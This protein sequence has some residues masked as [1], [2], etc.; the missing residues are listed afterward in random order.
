MFAI[1][2]KVYEEAGETGK[3][4]VYKAKFDKL[5][6]KAEADF[7]KSNQTKADAEAYMQKHVDALAAMAEQDANLVVNFARRC[8]ELFPD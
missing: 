4:A 3:S 5:A 6:L 8:D 2:A 1:V 7:K